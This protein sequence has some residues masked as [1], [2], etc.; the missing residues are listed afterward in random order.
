[1]GQK[2]LMKIFN[3]I[4]NNQRG[5]ALMMIITSIVI[6]T[7]IYSEFTFE[8]KISR[9]KTTNILDKS[10]AK[11]LAESGLQLAMTRLRLYK[12]AY[13]KVQ[14]NKQIKDLVSA[15]LLNQLWE[16]PFI[17]PIPITSEASAGF[18]S[19]VEKFQDE[20]LL[21][22][23]MKVS[24]QNISNRLN[25]NLLRLDMTKITT[26]DEINSDSS[27]INL[28]GSSEN[29]GEISI[30]QMIFNILKI[31]IDYK[32]QQDE[33]FQA[34]ASS[35]NYQNMISSLKY[36]ISDFQQ[37]STD[38][39]LSEAE[40]GFQKINI[41]PKFG[42]LASSSELYM[43]P[44][45]NDEI[46]ELVLNEFSSHPSSQIDLNQISPT[47]LKV[48]LPVMATN[49][50]YITDFF[51]YKNDTENPKFFNSIEDLKKY[52]VDV[53][54]LMGA[55][56]FDERIQLFQAKGVT[57]GPNPNFFK[58]ISEGTYNRSN[59]TLIAFVL[60]P[61]KTDTTSSNSNGNRTNSNT[62]TGNI[63]SEGANENEEGNSTNTTTNGTNTT[64]QTTQLLEPKIIEIQIN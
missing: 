9:I 11:L 31:N 25:L 4:L 64:N 27:E 24:V 39:Y 20:S 29:A 50:D 49:E 63:S 62:T 51:A 60:I 47:L 46:V 12:E 33:L 57:F 8:S 23:E 36:Y 22:G 37:V 61:L 13:N 5:V 54:Q 16:V 18:K 19:T 56:D 34:R 40:D 59:Y 6:L 30:A 55:T 28:G 10:Q 7:A 38:P 15:Q 21:E 17:Y 42:P 58:I 53:A 1:M 48:L 3:K 41:S 26:E 43:I 14:S 35:Y 45:W 44:G 2:K 32:S 52:I